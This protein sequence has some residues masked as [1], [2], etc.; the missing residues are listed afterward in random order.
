MDKRIT[1][2]NG[3]STKDEEKATLRKMAECALP[4]SYLASLFTPEFINWVE[5]QIRDDGCADLFGALTE[6]YKRE[7]LKMQEIGALDSQVRNNRYVVEQKDKQIADLQGRLQQVAEDG[8]ERLR[9]ANRFNESLR[10]ENEKTVALRYQMS[11]LNRQIAALKV[12]LYDLEHPI[13]Q[14]ELSE[15]VIEG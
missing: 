13:T 8:A 14:A 15:V 11:D 9:I 4:G 10:E 5:Q 6:E 12:R 1:I 2:V 3:Q 7:G